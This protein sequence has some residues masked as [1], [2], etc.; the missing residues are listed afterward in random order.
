MFLLESPEYGHQVMTDTRWLKTSHDRCISTRCVSN[1]LQNAQI[2]SAFTSGCSSHWR[3]LPPCI[4]CDES[5]CED[6]LRSVGMCRISAGPT[7]GFLLSSG[8]WRFRVGLA[9]GYGDDSSA[10]AHGAG[11]CRN[12]QH[13]TLR[14]FNSLYIQI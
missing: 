1:I 8:V 12:I 2:G 10:N 11:R 13:S 4:D 6:W 9:S 7:P 5:S 14:I 3:W